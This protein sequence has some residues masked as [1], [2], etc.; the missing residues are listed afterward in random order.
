M[1][2]KTQNNNLLSFPITGTVLC[3]L[4]SLF[5]LNFSKNHRVSN[6]VSPFYS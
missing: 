1:E 4:Y 3:A 5:H 6:T 2:I